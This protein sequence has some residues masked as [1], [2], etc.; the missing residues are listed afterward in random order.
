MLEFSDGLNARNILDLHKKFAQRLVKAD[1]SNMFLCIF[2][3]TFVEHRKHLSKTSFYR[4]LQSQDSTS[5]FTVWDADNRFAI[6][7]KRQLSYYHTLKPPDSAW[8][9]L[10]QSGHK[11]LSVF[12]YTA[13]FLFNHTYKV[14]LLLWQTSLTNRWWRILKI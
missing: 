11:P 10:S 3:T 6:S 8:Q 14:R 4:V 13:L 1:N 9:V 2:M 5:L 12:V 7:D